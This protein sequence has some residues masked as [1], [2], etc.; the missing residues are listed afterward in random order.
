MVSATFRGSCSTPGSMS[1]KRSSKNGVRLPPVGDVAPDVARCDAFVPQL[2]RHRRR[3]IAVD[4]RDDDARA[5]FA[6]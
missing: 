1:G 3:A 2:F 6:E 5:C 4:I